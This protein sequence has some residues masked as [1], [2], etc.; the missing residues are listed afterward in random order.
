MENP[1]A[2][3]LSTV[4]HEGR[5]SSRVVLLKGV[6]SR[7]FVFYTNL[8]SRKAREIEGNPN[9]C[10]SFYWRELGRQVYVEGTIKPVSDEEADAYFATRPRTSQLGAWASRQSQPLSSKAHLIKEVARHE[11]RFL[12][13]PVPRPPFW[14][15]YR[16]EPSSIELWVVG[17][18]RLHDRFVY[19]REEG[20]WQRTRLFP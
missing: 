2:M 10:L 19:K 5:L 1:D 4:D 17:A 13:R 20:D 8:G 6:D 9:V 15:G 11:A 7:G 14:S 16:V 18:F 3:V 12:A